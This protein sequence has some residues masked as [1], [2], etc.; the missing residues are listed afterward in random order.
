M[1]RNV[2]KQMI[3]IFKLLPSKKDQY[4]VENRHRIDVIFTLN[5]DKEHN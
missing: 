4:L 2:F 1:K 5:V 3:T